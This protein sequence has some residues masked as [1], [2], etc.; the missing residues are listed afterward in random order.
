MAVTI[1]LPPAVEQNLLAQANVKGETLE[2]HLSSLATKWAGKGLKKP[3]QFDL[4]KIHNDVLQC[5]NHR[6]WVVLTTLS[7]FAVVTGITISTA[8]PTETPVAV[9]P[10][11]MKTPFR[12]IAP[13]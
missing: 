9:A 1:N 12:L 10:I 5:I 8:K 13:R 3:D 7:V 4:P 11:D 6:F 2:V